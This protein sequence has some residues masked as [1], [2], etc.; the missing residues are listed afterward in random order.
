MSRKAA[1][2]QRRQRKE[3][4]MSLSSLRFGGFA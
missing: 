3:L 4:L 2:A 1:K